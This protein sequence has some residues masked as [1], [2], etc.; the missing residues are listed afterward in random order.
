[1]SIITF[2]TSFQDY[3][4]KKKENKISGFR[5]SVNIKYDADFSDLFT[6]S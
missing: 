1:M 2:K 4:G 5:L 6:S 3:A